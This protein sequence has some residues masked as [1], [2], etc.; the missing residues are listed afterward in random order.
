MIAIYSDSQIIDLEWLPKLGLT[1]AHTIY[2]NFAQYQQAPAQIKLAFTA[3]RLHQTYDLE[4]T[5]GV[6][7]EQRVITLSKASDLVF[8]FESELHNFHW[9]IWHHC[10]RPN[11]YWLQPGA[12]NDRT[13]MQDHII[14]WQDFLKLVALMY[15]RLPDKLIQLQP[16]TEKPKFFDALLGSLKP[17]RQ[18][19]AKA[20]DQH[21]LHAKFVMTYGGTWNNDKFYAQDY[22][23]W[24]PG[25][26]PEQ[27]I[28]GTADY[29][30]YDGYL[31]P[32]SHVMPIQVYN[33][34]AYSIVCETDHDNTLSFF[35]EKTAKVLVARR[36][37][38]AFTGYRFLYNL[39]QL[40]FQTFDGIIDESYDLIKH[41]G[42]RYTAAFEQVRYLCSVPQSQILPKIRSI[43]DHNHS[44]IMNTDWT[45]FAAD[46]ISARIVPLLG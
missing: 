9:V 25:C 35:S 46:K 37:F 1:H 18:F 27:D 43:V 13:D 41:D 44:V 4:S 12:V 15:K 8:V 34:T 39:R 16:Y 36:L 5:N 30:K 32:L 14:P 42:D 29:V 17:H 40:G 21:H 19:V 24:E 28:I 11:V 20:V 2:H 45:Q 31:T 3:Q 7:F 33:D 23:I 22:F 38:V 6:T 26:V 10:H